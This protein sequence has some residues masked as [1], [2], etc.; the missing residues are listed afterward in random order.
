MKRVLPIVTF[1]LAGLVVC[2]IG[3]AMAADPPKA[4]PAKTTPAKPAAAAP[5]PAAAPA[6]PFKLGYVDLQRTLN[7]TAAG[8]SARKKLEADKDKKQKELDAKQKELQKFAEELEKQQAVLKPEVLNKRRQE[9]QEKY[10]ALQQTYLQLQQDLAKNE[11]KLVR[12][13]YTKASPII[14]KIAK[15]DGYTMI[16][17]QSAVLWAAPGYDITDKVNKA[18]K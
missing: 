2:S 14:Q 6:G 9:L 4:A 10:V 13:I 5:A 3:I 11:A 1:G 16:V 18:V 8:K 15:D 17:D 12:E 7:E